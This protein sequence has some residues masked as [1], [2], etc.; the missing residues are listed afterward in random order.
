MKSRSKLPWVL[1]TGGFVGG[2]LAT[3]LAPGTIKWYFT[4]PAQFGFNCTGPIEWAIERFQWALAGGI[5]LGMLVALVV[6]LKF[7]KPTTESPDPEV[8]P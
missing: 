3:W 6:Y 2:A 5:L 1:G 4:P 8:L 7:R